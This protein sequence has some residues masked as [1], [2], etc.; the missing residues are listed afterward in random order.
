MTALA[1]PAVLDIRAAA[2]L[3][4]DL[5][6]RRGSDIVLDGGEVERVGGLCLQVLISAKKTWDADGKGFAL[7]PASTALNEQLAAY[8]CADLNIDPVGATR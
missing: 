2:P 5:L 3:R 8:G 6:A 7:N 1:L 4:D